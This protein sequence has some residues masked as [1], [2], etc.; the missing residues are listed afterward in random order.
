MKLVRL[1]LTEAD[2]GAPRDPEKP[3]LLSVVT[4]PEIGR[5]RMVKV[6]EETLEAVREGRVRDLVIAYYT[7]DHILWMRDVL[8]RGNVVGVGMAENLKHNILTR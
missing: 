8:T 7:D 3:T 5:E 6:L 2:A 4:Y 1:P